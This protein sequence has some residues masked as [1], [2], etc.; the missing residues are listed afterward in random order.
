LAIESARAIVN[1]QAAH[2]TLGELFLSPS[3]VPKNRSAAQ[4][5]AAHEITRRIESLRCAPTKLP[6]DN[7]GR[8]NDA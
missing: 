1:H 2:R 7:F 8:A 3:H 5:R 4:P 6:S